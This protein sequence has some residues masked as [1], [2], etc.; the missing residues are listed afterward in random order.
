MECLDANVVQDLMA[1][2]LE[3]PARVLAIEHLDGCQ[4]CRDLIALLA[5][6]ATHDVAVDTLNDTEKRVPMSMMETVGSFDRKPHERGARSNPEGIAE[7]DRGREATVALG[8]GRG[9]DEDDAMGVTLAPNESITK[10]VRIR[11]PNKVGTTLGRYKIIERA[12]RISRPVSARS[13]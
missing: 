5:K 9:D 7:V 4:D 2:A 1:G 11:A 3:P 6:A 12:S 8:T 10:A 13:G